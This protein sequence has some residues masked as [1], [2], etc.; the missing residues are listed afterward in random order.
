MTFSANSTDAVSKLA[1]IRDY[2]W[3]I[4][5]GILAESGQQCTGVIVAPRYAITNPSCVLSRDM[6]WNIRSG[7]SNP[8]LYGMKHELDKVITY[9]DSDEPVYK[10]IGGGI[11]LIRVKEPFSYGETC[12]PISIIEENFQPPGTEA[13]YLISLGQL[14]SKDKPTDGL[15]VLPVKVRDPSKCGRNGVNGNQAICVSMQNF[16]HGFVKLHHD[17]ILIVNGKFAGI[18]SW[19]GGWNFKGRI[20]STVFQRADMYRDWIFKNIDD[21]TKPA[22]DHL[23]DNLSSITLKTLTCYV[24][25]RALQRNEARTTQFVRALMDMI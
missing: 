19:Y 3:I 21:S 20:E 5:T 18:G 12:K 16:K 25:A 7:S 11:I 15:R 17:V 22:Q 9:T 10:K 23:D 6:I 24:A 2:P 13:A 4:L 8:R 1:D 14:T